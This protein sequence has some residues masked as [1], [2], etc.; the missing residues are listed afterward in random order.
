MGAL[1]RGRARP[2]FVFVGG[3]YDLICGVGIFGQDVGFYLQGKCLR[4]TTGGISVK[5]QI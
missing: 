5:L 4:R 1:G 2:F 3:L